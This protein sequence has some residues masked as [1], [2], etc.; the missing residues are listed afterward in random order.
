MEDLNRLLAA[1][2][3]APVKQLEL[4]RQVSTTATGPV[5]PAYSAALALAARALPPSPPPV[6]TPGYN[7]STFDSVP[8]MESGPEPR[9]YAPLAPDRYVVGG[10]PY[11]AS[12]FW[13][14]GWGLAGA[15]MGF[16]AARVL[17]R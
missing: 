14:L 6:V 2:V 4:A 15:V 5:I 7:P 9:E 16:V 3:R 13:M 1:G 8:G 17:W 12:Y 10:S 11:N